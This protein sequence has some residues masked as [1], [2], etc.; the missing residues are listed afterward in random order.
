[1][2]KYGLLLLISIAAPFV[3]SFWPGLKFYRHLK[4]LVA[5]IA[6][7]VL[8]FGSWDVFAAWRG[9][10]SFA[11]GAVCG[12]RVL[13]LP[14]EELLFFVVVPFCCIFTWEAL[15]FLRRRR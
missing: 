14:L 2:S 13:G 11:P 5:S 6:F 3:L 12:I 1:M 15:E 7:I 8:I 10:W 4:A 9:H